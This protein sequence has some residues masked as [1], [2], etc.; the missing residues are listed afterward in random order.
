MNEH[1]LLRFVASLGRANVGIVKKI[2]LHPLDCAQLRYQ[3]RRRNRYRKQSDVTAAPD[4]SG[5]EIVASDK[6]EEDVAVCFNPMNEIIACPRLTPHA[7]RR[8]RPIAELL[9]ESDAH[10]TL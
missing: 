8:R 7:R 6:V 9:E 3:L 4:F 5:I 10:R 2:M 1:E